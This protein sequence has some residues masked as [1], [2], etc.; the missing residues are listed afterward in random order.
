MNGTAMLS[1]YSWRFPSPF[2]DYIFR[3]NIDGERNF[4]YNHDHLHPLVQFY[5]FI[6]DKVKLDISATLDIM[7]QEVSTTLQFI[8]RLILIAS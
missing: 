7:I 4:G 5:R 2:L 8:D 1:D 3:C 6:D